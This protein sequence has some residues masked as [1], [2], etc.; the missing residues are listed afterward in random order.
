MRSM[1]WVVSVLTQ[2]YA[3]SS[4]KIIDMTMSHLNPTLW[5]AACFFGMLFFI[6]ISFILNPG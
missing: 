1:V 6:A 5:G 3:S 2:A 4:Q